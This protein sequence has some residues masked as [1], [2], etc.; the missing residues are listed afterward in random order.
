MKIIPNFFGSSGF[1]CTF[2]IA[3]KIVVVHSAGRTSDAQLSQPG[4]FN[5]KKSAGRCKRA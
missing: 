2:A 4:I 5:A 3:S 1:F